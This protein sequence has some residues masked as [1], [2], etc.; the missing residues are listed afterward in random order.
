MSF[1]QLTADFD[2]YIRNQV[3]L[4]PFTVGSGFTPY[5]GGLVAINA[6]GAAVA[7]SGSN[8]ANPTIGQVYEVSPD[9]TLVSIRMGDVNLGVGTST[10]TDSVPVQANVGSLLYAASD[11]QVTTA[12]GTNGKVGK[13]MGFDTRTGQP[14]VRIGM[15]IGF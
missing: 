14:I 15:S 10:A 3:S 6:A 4:S 9:S 8:T 1:S 13:L 7:V 12:S 5:V 11:W 2:S